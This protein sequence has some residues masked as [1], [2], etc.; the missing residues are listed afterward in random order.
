MKFSPSGHFQG[1]TRAHTHTFIHKLVCGAVYVCNLL[2]PLPS[3]CVLLSTLRP[4]QPSAHQ[5][6]GRHPRG[7]TSSH[8]TGAE[9]GAFREPS[10]L[11]PSTGWI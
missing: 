11:G 8:S 7:C 3:V 6:L 2:T 10:A 1:P 9:A 4:H 5:R